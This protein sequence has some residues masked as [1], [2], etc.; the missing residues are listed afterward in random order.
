MKLL[1]AMAAC[2]AICSAVPMSLTSG[3]DH[4]VQRMAVIEKTNSF[5]GRLWTAAANSR[6]A[7]LPVGASRSL[8]GVLPGHKEH[9]LARVA[10]GTLGI[11]RKQ[12]GLSLP[13]SFDSEA[14][15]PECA[16]VIGDIRDQSNCGC[17]WAFGA[18]EAA[19]DRLCIATGGAVAVPLS[20][21]ETCFCANPDGCGGGRLDAAWDYIQGHGVA[22]GGQFNATGQLGGGFCSAFSLP[23]CHHHGPQVGTTTTTPTPTPTHTDP[24]L[25]HPAAH[26]PYAPQRRTARP[27]SQ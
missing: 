10:A 8:C 14:N 21:Q 13:E 9:L 23:H 20:A 18:A 15:W 12:S 3:E 1:I 4:D 6:F 24:H 11:V 17:C 5:P 19:S 27:L 2:L 7:G 22:T 26:T 16:K 25:H